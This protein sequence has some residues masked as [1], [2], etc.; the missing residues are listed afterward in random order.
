[1]KENL[2]FLK[3]LLKLLKIKSTNIW[4][5]YQKTVDKLD[6]RVNEYNNKCHR[7]IK[8]KPTDVKTRSYIDF[9]V[10]NNEK[11]PKFKVGNKVRIPKYSFSW[12]HK[13]LNW[14][15]KNNNI[16]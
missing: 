9:D 16:F 14:L 2:L 6:N 3:D 11:D 1:M 8:M 7:T 5:Q 13:T 4:L 12:Q 10:E 15:E